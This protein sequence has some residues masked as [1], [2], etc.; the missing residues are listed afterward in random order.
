LDELRLTSTSCPVCYLIFDEVSAPAAPCS[1]VNKHNRQLARI[2]QARMVGFEK[3]RALK[4]RMSSFSL[5][6]EHEAGSMPKSRA[7]ASDI[8]PD[9]INYCRSTRASIRGSVKTHLTSGIII[10][11]PLAIAESEVNVTETKVLKSKRRR[12]T[13]TKSKRKSVQIFV[14]VIPQKTRR[15]RSKRSKSSRKN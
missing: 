12:K 8:T 3:F 2:P 6:R 9:R 15:R 14:T 1:P 11:P 5:P 13:K 7:P 10:S 4:R